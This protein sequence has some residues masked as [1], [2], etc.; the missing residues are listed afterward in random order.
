MDHDQI[1]EQQVALTEAHLHYEKALKAHAYYKVNNQMLSTDLVQDTFIKTWD[2]LAK[3]G[4]IETMK[5]FL[6]HVLNNL[7][8]DEYR[9]R[10]TNSLDVLLEKGFEPK[11]DQ[12]E[13]LLD[14]LDGKK[15][16]L[17]IKKLPKAYQK[18]MQLKYTKGLSL[19]EISAQTG[20]SKE[21]VAVQLHRGLK[22]IKDLYVNRCQEA[23]SI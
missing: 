6:Y 17:L 14:Y 23:I 3:G 13:N 4:K 11:F 9:K 7:I 12:T 16:V 1:S 21:T 18:A 8:I 20:Q 2:Y 5:A 19:K 10:K 22:K 15:A